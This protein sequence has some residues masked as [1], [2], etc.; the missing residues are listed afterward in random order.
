MDYSPSPFLPPHKPWMDRL[1]ALFEVLSLSGVVSGILA[2]LPLALINRNSAETLSANFL[3]ATLFLES[4]F[5]FLILWIILKI[6]N[7]T[8]AGLGLR[9]IHWKS[10]FFIG[11][12]LVPVL[13]VINW[14]IAIFFKVFLP[15]YFLET[16]PLTD[17]IHSPV[18]L[19]FFTFAALIAG[20][21]KE[22]IQRAFIIRR[23]SR[24]LGGAGLGLLLWSLAFGAGHYVQ[25][26]QGVVTTTLL[27]FIFGMLYLLRGSLIGPIVAH[28]AYNTLALILYWFFSGRYA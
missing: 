22:E 27:G 9:L 25:G 8:L 5:F 18:Q 1:L 7:E 16:N 10:N 12:A 26:V 17:S 24:Y 6:H 2:T 19:I 3:S 23:F 13:I 4:A 21:L 20:G 15:K 28:A 14:L 11:L